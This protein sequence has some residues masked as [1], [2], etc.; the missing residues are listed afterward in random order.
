MHQ[1]FARAPSRT[2]LPDC[3]SAAAVTGRQCEQVIE[4]IKKVRAPNSFDRRRIVPP[5]AHNTTT[6]G[7]RLRCFLQCESLLRDALSSHN[8]PDLI[9]DHRR[10]R[11]GGLNAVGRGVLGV[12]R[13]Q[14]LKIQEVA[15]H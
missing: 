10:A 1:H 3:C 8:R 7:T 13:P 4:S 14:R 15:R 2:V 5:A 12:T 11:L 6:R 9:A